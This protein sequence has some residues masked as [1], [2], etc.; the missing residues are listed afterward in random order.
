[1]TSKP[2]K[3][4]GSD[5]MPACNTVRT[6]PIKEPSEAQTEEEEGRDFSGSLA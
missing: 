3:G 4:L 5:A 1:M 6:L 2:I